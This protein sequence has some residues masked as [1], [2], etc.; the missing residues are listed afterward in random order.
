MPSALKR[1]MFHYFIGVARKWGEKI[2]NKRTGAAGR[3]GCSIGSA[4]SWSMAPLK[5][6]LGF[7][8]MR[9]AYTAGEAIGPEICSPSIA[10]SD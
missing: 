7:S 8:R 3:R 4:M 1:K 9:V 10:R 6:V 5:N 2:L